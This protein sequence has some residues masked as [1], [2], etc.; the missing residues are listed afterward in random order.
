ML[1]DTTLFILFGKGLDGTLNPSLLTIDIGDVKNIT[2]TPIYH[3]A[4]DTSNDA[5]NSGTNNGGSG[6]SNGN[7]DGT[8]G[9][10]STN[11]KS[12]GLS[13]GAVGGIA[14]GCVIVVSIME[15]IRT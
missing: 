7:I 8:P 1:V 13:K 2:Y 4:A 9:E 12:D 6:G 14:A 11:G 15:L 3:G 10:S 5:G